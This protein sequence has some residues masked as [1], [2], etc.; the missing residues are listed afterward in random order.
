[1]KQNKPAFTYAAYKIDHVQYWHS[2]PSPVLRRLSDF[3]WFNVL[4]H[5]VIIC[6]EG[7][8]FAINAVTVS[9]LRFLFS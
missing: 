5:K 9:W 2:F 1:M 8:V 6:C 7:S 4:I 3:L